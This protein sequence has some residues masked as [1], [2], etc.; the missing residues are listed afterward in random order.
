M[1]EKV[2]VLIVDDQFAVLSVMAAM[3]FRAGYTVLT[4][5]DIKSALQTCHGRKV[6]L[7]LVDYSLPDGDGYQLALLLRQMFPEIRVALVSALSPDQMRIC[8]VAG[9]LPFLQK[10]FNSSGLVTFVRETLTDAQAVG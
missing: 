10:P 7:V 3:L 1:T 6:G 9:K 4:A 2:C 5:V 8:S